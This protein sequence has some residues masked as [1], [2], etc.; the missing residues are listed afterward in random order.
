MLSDNMFTEQGI[1]GISGILNYDTFYGFFK[2]E[3]KDKLVQ[4]GRYR[5]ASLV[6]F[7][8][9][10]SI[11]G[12]NPH[13]SH[14]INALLYGLLCLI[15]Y[16][17][18]LMWFSTYFQDKRLLNFAF[19]IALVFA[20]HP[21]HVE[22]VANIKGRDELFV[23]LFGLLS[24]LL[25]FQKEKS[26]W[27][28]VLAYMS[29]FIA[30]FSKE[31]AIIF[32]IIIPLSVWFFGRSRK[33][34]KQL[35]ISTIPVVLLGILFLIVRGNILGTTISPAT[36]ELMNNPFLKL[37]NG[38]LIDYS[39]QEKWS[40]IIYNLGKYLQLMVFPFPLTSDYYPYHISA[41]SFMDFRVILSIIVHIG[42]V[43]S[44]IF[45]TLKRKPWAFGILFYFGFLFLVSNLPFNIGT[46][47]SE[48]FLFLP[49]VGFI[50]TAVYL[51]FTYLLKTTE[52]SKVYRYLLICVLIA[53]SLYSVYRSR[54]WKNDFTLLT[55]DVIYSSNS[56]KALHGAAGALF[57]EASKTK[58]DGLKKQYLE[59]STDY[60]KKA[61]EIYPLYTNAYLI[62]GNNYQL[63]EQYEDAIKSY[64]Q[65]LRLSPEH[66]N[67]L[68]NL[69]IAYRDAG[70]Y[71]G[72]KVGD[73]NKSTAY[74]NEAYK[75]DPTSYETVRLLGVSNGV[76]GN[77]K[78]AIQYFELGV[79]LNPNDAFAWFNLG[80]AYFN[81]KD[82]ENG[83]RCH[84]KTLE[85]DPSFADKIKK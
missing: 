46:N 81:N 26:W 33:D 55:T 53:F 44:A 60:I 84:A 61:L 42:L 19:V 52:R 8:L 7:A 31:N 85:I 21:I 32:M 17:L 25:L 72:E 9:E 34:Q 68:N 78:E 11:F 38:I 57:T 3:G 40:T 5:P 37:E 2:V 69:Q 1:N 41:K 28:Y 82:Q 66:K 6:S 39:F 27:H 18:L 64:N 71:Y 13:V 62:Q 80:N 70:R 45:G 59:L 24:A 16:R 77:V 73:M 23:A 12:G 43:L 14:C 29:I 48:R 54:V 36:N 35:W 47:I 83:N 74:L 79:E 75:M 49:S 67:G 22:V 63:L 10:Q 56:A 65:L 30:Y 51:V 58:D 20:C 76:Q 4:G 50:I 15:L